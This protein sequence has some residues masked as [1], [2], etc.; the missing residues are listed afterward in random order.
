MLWCFFIVFV[1][2]MVD[3]CGASPAGPGA[4]EDDEDEGV[5]EYAVAVPDEALYGCEQAGGGEDGHAVLF[6]H[7]AYEVLGVSE[8]AAKDV[9]V[10]GGEGEEGGQPA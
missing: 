9:D 1:E 4:A 3:V 2:F 5:A 7:G 10:G 8:A 6:G